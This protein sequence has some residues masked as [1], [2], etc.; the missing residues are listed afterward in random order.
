MDVVDAT[1]PSAS[2]D[3]HDQ[4]ENDAD[5]NAGDDGKIKHGVTTLDANIAGKVPQPFRGEAAPENKA[6]HG[7][8]G[9]RYY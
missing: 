7:D 5:D 4:T 9:A 2:K 8:D 1:L 6:N 3:R